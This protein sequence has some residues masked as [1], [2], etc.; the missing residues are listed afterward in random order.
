MRVDDGP[1]RPARLSGALS[2]DAWAQWLV[3]WD[4][5]PGDRRLQVRAVDGT[6]EVQTAEDAPPAPSGA[7]GHHTVRV[8]VG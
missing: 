4:A 1:W 5:T 2:G 7:T 6:G 3:D 8:T